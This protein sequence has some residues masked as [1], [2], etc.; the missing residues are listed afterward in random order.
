MKQCS[1]LE[2]QHYLRQVYQQTRT[3]MNIGV[4]LSEKQNE[5]EMK[6]TGES[7]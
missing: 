3:E 4:S 5:M 6:V 7:K 2:F 1:L